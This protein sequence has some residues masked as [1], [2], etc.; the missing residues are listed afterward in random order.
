[1]RVAENLKFNVPRTR[2]I[3]LDVHS[4]I[5]KRGLGLARSTFQSHRKVVLAMHNSHA[6]AAAAGCGFDQN[7]IADLIGM[8]RNNLCIGFGKRRTGSDGDA[9]LL[10]KDARFNLIAEQAH[11]VCRGA[12]KDQSCIT[13]CL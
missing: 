11:G 10:S 8:R 12:D 3:L 2:E 6:L 9:N 4:G 1:M 7:G 13:D 5:S